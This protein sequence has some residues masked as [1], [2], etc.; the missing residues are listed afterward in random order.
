L[1]AS[2]R[3]HVEYVTFDT[4]VAR[5]QYVARRF[6]DRLRGSVLDVGC[7][8]GDLKN[9]LSGVEYLGV[10]MAPSADLC[11]NL[12]S[13]DRLP[14]D[15]ASFDCVVCI[16]VLEHLDNLHTIWRE[17]VRVARSSI[18]I[19]WHN[20]WVNARR[21]LT[22]G[23][24]GF[25]HY[26]LPFERPMDRHKWFFSFEQAA[27]F[28]DASCAAMPISLAASFATEKPRPWPLR[29]LRRLRYPAQLRYLNRYAHTLWTVFDA[30]SPG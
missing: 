17:I 29:W 15:D 2:R 6:Q 12:E 20:C 4:R 30:R 28:V 13:I 5:L 14:F 8:V 18:I 7:D 19:S 10:D 27:A 25:S 9:Y 16:D 21:P 22:R 11:L 26:G 23:A 1:T 3:F 24:G